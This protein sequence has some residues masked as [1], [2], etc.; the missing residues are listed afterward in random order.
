MKKINRFILSWG[1]ILILITGCGN[2]NA[3]HTTKNNNVDDVLN[4]QI[5]NTENTTED[6]TENTTENT[7]ENTTG[8]QD[9]DIDYDLTQ[10]GSDM[11]YATVYQLMVNPNDYI[12]KTIKMNGLYYAAYYE[13]TGQYY[14]YCIIKDA[15]ACCA[16]GMEFVWDNGNHKYPDDYP[17]D[18]SEITVTGTFETYQED[19][20]SNLY[21]RLS[22]AAMETN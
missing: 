12:G 11:I 16:Q 8:M 6:T 19:N 1:L 21:C 10:M 2:D 4:Q 15:T 5:N 20:D 13:P 3:G 18:Y 17:E 22:N 14:H 7:K 9:T